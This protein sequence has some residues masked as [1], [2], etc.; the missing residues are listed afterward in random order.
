MADY[1]VTKLVYKHYRIW[2]SDGSRGS[3]KG[4]V[5][6]GVIVD[7]PE[8]ATPGEWWAL[9]KARLHYPHLFDGIENLP[10]EAGTEDL[11]ESLLRTLEKNPSMRFWVHKKDGAVQAWYAAHRWTGEHILP[12]GGYCS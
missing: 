12:A 7:I 10:A 1:L 3:F 2:P 5:K 4:F 8:D 6:E 11:K 9:S